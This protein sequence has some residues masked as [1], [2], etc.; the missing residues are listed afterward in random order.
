MFCICN[1]STIVSTAA[2]SCVFACGCNFAQIPS[3]LSQ[4]RLRLS[5]VQLLLTKACDGRHLLQVRTTLVD[6]TPTASSNN[7]SAREV[8]LFHTSCKI[9]NVGFGLLFPSR[10]TGTRRSSAALRVSVCP[11]LGGRGVEYRPTSVASTRQ[12]AARGS[13]GERH[14]L[15]DPGC[16][17]QNATFEIRR[18]LRNVLSRPANELETVALTPGE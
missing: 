18:Y 3:P 2:V 17:N 4:L 9:G 13:G 1:I 8:A 15:E 7:G 12:S 14:E 11:A 10:N 6:A 5:E 16:K